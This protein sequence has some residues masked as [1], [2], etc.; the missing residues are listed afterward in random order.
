MS[1][2]AQAPT[3]RLL[4][5][6]VGWDAAS[7]RGLSGLDGDGISLERLGNPWTS[8][9]ISRALP[10]ARLARGCG[11]CEW[12]LVTP[13]PPE[14]RLLRKGR[15]D[16]SWRAM[17]ECECPPAPVECAVAVAAH[18]GDIAIADDGAHKIWLL[19]DDGRLLRT[20]IPFSSPG[21][22]VHARWGAW[23]VVDREQGT[24]RSF[25]AGGGET[26]SRFPALPGFADRIGADP[27][28]RAWVVTV[29]DGRYRIWWA[30]RGAPEWRETDLDALL[31]AFPNTG[32]TD[33][34]VDSFC[35]GDAPPE[36]R[37]GQCCSSWYGRPA[38][39]VVQ[40]MPRSPIYATRGQLL[41]HALDSGIPRCRWH[42]VRID[43]LVP[44]ES[45][46]RVA[47]STHEEADPP[48]QGNEPDLEWQD[49][50]AGVPHPQDWQT[51]PASSRDFLISQPPGRYLFVR[52]RMTGTDHQSPI[53]HQVRLDFPRQSS[54]E[55]LPGIY[56][57]TPD[58][59]DFAERFLSLFDAA[60]ESIDR[61]IE[62]SPALLD[63]QGVP[64]EILPWLGSFLDVA[65]DGAWTTER[66]RKV[67]KAVPDLY[68]RR[69][70]VAGLRDT[71]RLLHDIDPVIQ[72]SALE[73][74][75]GAVGSG[76]LGQVRL[77][78]PAQARFR[79]G[80]SPL[81][82]APLQS[83]GDPNLDPV[84]T[85]S[86]RF[87]VFLPGVLTEPDRLRIAAL[88][89]SQKPAHTVATVAGSRRGLVLGPASRV[90][91]DTALI[92]SDAPVLGRDLRLNRASVLW[93]GGCRHT[94]AIQAGQ[95]AA[96]GV[97]TVVE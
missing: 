30:E 22:L 41:T 79:V 46:L 1:C 34:T 68:R 74:M 47:V 96:V 15:C 7:I 97:S 8:A 6:R 73:R 57:E 56:R 13:S 25:D 70:T 58:A 3:F 86:F 5:S 89:E 64:P 31:D 60:V 48:A 62:R 23:L 90:G 93:H 20:A 51:G 75:W 65:M 36:K 37:N 53:L 66:R 26:P 9:D 88:V 84:T 71:V 21:P 10:P 72:E 92:A 80:R 63:T 49:F 67:L 91:V 45:T 81:G 24:L 11:P 12:F 14:S 40:P 38:E 2:L 43:A 44:D 33:V 59:E 17:W 28:G 61:A 27:R 54:A 42:R 76:A 94:P 87:R 16:G 19:G 50:P 29:D 35:V 77:F 82:R 95:F 55:R 39:P 32:I 83:F 18:C 69:G 78:S 52:I 85:Q 4:D